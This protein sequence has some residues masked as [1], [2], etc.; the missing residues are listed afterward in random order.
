MAEIMVILEESI[1][2]IPKCTGEN[3]LQQLIN[4]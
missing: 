2:L 4:A 3:N 1:K